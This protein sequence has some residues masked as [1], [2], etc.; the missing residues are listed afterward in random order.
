MVAGEAPGAFD[1]L[2]HGLLSRD[3][4]KGPL[5]SSPPSPYPT[6]G[7]KEVMGQIHVLGHA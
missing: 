1:S 2:L 7:K 6:T 3:G 4:Y 5:L